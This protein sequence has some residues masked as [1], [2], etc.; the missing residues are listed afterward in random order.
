[1]LTISWEIKLKVLVLP[2]HLKKSLDYHSDSESE[3]FNLKKRCILHK[4][5]M[6]E[7]QTECKNSTHWNNILFIFHESISLEFHI[8]LKKPFL[9]DVGFYENSIRIKINF[10]FLWNMKNAC[11]MYIQIDVFSEEKKKFFNPQN[12]LINRR[13][14]IRNIFFLKRNEKK[15]VYLYLPFLIEWNFVE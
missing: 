11:S 2:H 13:L 1:M 4:T 9:F 7:T 3:F 15:T 10:I 6:R 8:S 5:E 12:C 14:Q